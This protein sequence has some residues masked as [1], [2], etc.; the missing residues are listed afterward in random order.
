MDSFEKISS[1]NVKNFISDE[2]TSECVRFYIHLSMASIK[3]MHNG[4]GT[5]WDGDR[6]GLGHNANGPGTQWDWYTTGLGH[7]GMGTQ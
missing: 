6:V 5:Q 2:V 7:D 4:H 1:L 3:S